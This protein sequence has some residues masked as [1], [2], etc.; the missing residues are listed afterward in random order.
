MMTMVRQIMVPL[1]GSALAERALPGAVRLATATGATLRLVRV[2]EPLPGDVSV[3]G[4]VTVP[5]RHLDLETRAAAEYLEDVQVRVATEGVRVETHQRVGHALDTLLK[6]QRSTR[7]DLV[8]MCGRGHGGLARAALGS[9]AT[10]LVQQGTAPVLLARTF[11]DPVSLDQAVVPLDGSA[12]AEA[13]LRLVE[14]LAGSV[15]HE[16][17]LLRVIDAPVQGP[18]AER[19][20]EQVARSLRA[21]GVRCTWQ[22]EQGQPAEHIRAVAGRSKLVVMS[23]RGHGAVRRWALGSVADRVARD[24]GL[25]VL[26]AR[27]GAVSDQ[28]VDIEDHADDTAPLHGAASGGDAAIQHGV[29]RALARHGGVAAPDVGV[30]VDDGVVTLHETVSSQDKRH[31]AQGAA[32]RVP[33]VRDVANNIAVKLPGIGTPTDT[34]L[35]QAVRTALELQESVPHQRLRTTV[36]DGWVTLQGTVDRQSEREA[37]ERAV[38]G[39]AGVR[40]CTSV[41]MVRARR[42]NADAESMAWEYHSE[43]G[44]R[45]MTMDPR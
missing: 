36:S 8:V 12:H 26:L 41:V 44:D 17:T 15:I 6:E 13:A 10:G 27:A 23:T 5:S 18:D 3:Y 7:I 34:E 2:V 35:A 37:A 1:D 19:Y 39:V 43:A 9:V 45:P 25:D 32:Y 40:G 33:H 21:T 29:L 38:H 30:E 4:P 22:V 28:D 42:L 16:V 14:R 11:G 24:G 20:L 31:A